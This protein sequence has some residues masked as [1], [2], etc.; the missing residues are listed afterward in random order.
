MPS[1]APYL[2]SAHI[3]RNRTPMWM[4]NCAEVLASRLKLRT[5][6][7]QTFVY[8]KFVAEKP[9][10]IIPDMYLWSRVDESGFILECLKTSTACFITY[11]YRYCCS[12][13][14]TAECP[15][16]FFPVLALACRFFGQRVCGSRKS[17]AT[18]SGFLRTKGN[19]PDSSKCRA[20]A[21]Y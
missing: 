6:E 16:L 18:C 14:F 10:V 4:K 1:S 5:D 12:L 8:N 19:R 17:G 15:L 9:C 3:G 20:V 21:Y 2:N 13:E 7:N 11:L